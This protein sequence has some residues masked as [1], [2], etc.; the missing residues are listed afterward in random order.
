MSIVCVQHD[1]L[2]NCLWFMYYILVSA[3]MHAVCVR[4]LRHD[5]D[6]ITIMLLTGWWRRLRKRHLEWH[7]F[8]CTNPT[9]SSS[10]IHFFGHNKKDTKQTRIEIRLHVFIFSPNMI[11]L[12][13]NDQVWTKHTGL[14]L[15]V[16]TT[17]FIE[18][19]CIVYVWS[20][21][22]SVW[23][24]LSLLLT[25]TVSTTF[26]CSI[27]HT[28]LDLSHSRLIFCPHY[29]VCVCVCFIVTGVLF[30]RKKTT[31]GK[32]N[33]L[34]FFTEV[35][36]KLSEVNQHRGLWPFWCNSCQDIIIL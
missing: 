22:Q 9:T 18:V 34:V 31:R 32:E 7:S 1:S 19:D 3:C 30:T 29:C 15:T 36:D 11:I 13:M 20:F 12:S 25:T 24:T 14:K 5:H 28:T 2:T 4:F 35:T 17:W 27:S 33:N 10:C 26:L 21:F 16:I 8:Q 6:V 23:V